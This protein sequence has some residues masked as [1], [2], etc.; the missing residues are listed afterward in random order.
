MPHFLKQSHRKR[1][2]TCKGF[3]TEIFDPSVSNCRG[4]PIQSE[5][6]LKLEQRAKVYSTLMNGYDNDEATELFRQFKGYCG[7]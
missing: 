1:Y 7:A 2:S 6:D 3:P 4:G 5:V